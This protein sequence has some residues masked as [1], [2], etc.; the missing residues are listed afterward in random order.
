MPGSSGWPSLR[1]ACSARSCAPRRPGPGL[2]MPKPSPKTWK[3]CRRPVRR[4]TCNM[5]GAAGR[6]HAGSREQLRRH[7][8]RGVDAEGVHTHLRG[9]SGRSCRAAR[10]ARRVLGVQVVQARHLEVQ[11]LLRLLVVGDVGRPVVDAGARCAGL[12]G[13][14]QVERRLRR[15]PAPGVS[16]SLG[17]S[18]A[19][20]RPARQP[21]AVAEEVA[22]VVEHDVLHQVHAAAVQRVRQ[23]R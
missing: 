6:R 22:G 16:R 23:R 7:I 1:R 17:C 13:S 21:V 11:L 2:S 12:R 3:S 15:A 18:R 4:A 10:G 5:P 9:S 14:L 20:G 19:P 8:E